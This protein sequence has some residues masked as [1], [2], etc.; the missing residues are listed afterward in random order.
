MVHKGYIIE[1]TL[2]YILDVI[3]LNLFIYSI[4]KI[5]LNLRKSNKNEIEKNSILKIA[6]N[7]SGFIKSII[8]L[9]YGIDFR[10]VHGIYPFPIRRM[11]NL[12]I[13]MIGIINISFIIYSTNKFNLP[14]G[15]N[16]LHVKKKLLITNIVHFLITIII[17]ILEITYYVPERNKRENSKNWDKYMI[18]IFIYNIWLILIFI[19]ILIYGFI[20]THNTLSNINDAI[21]DIK[22]YLNIDYARKSRKNLLIFISIGI[23]LIFVIITIIIFFLITAINTWNIPSS[24]EYNNPNNYEIDPSILSVL[25][26]YA[27]VWYGWVPSNKEKDMKN[28]I[29]IAIRRNTLKQKLSSSV[30]IHNKSDDKDDFIDINL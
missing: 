14:F 19:F 4:Y 10:G 21:K 22:G 25:S 6:F 28:E 7:V 16:L 24:L 5:R 15:N 18:S 29:E 27:I 2:F 9:I 26:S 8:L 11:F 13:I 1:Q 23:T 17:V 12:I 30:K 20:I 3:A